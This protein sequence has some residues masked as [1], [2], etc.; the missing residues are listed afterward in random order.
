MVTSTIKFLVRECLLVLQWV[1]R[2]NLIDLTI[3]TTTI[4][5]ISVLT[6]VVDLIVMNLTNTDDIL[7]IMTIVMIHQEEDVMAGATILIMPIIIIHHQADIM[8]G[9]DMLIMN[10]VI[11][12]I[13]NPCLECKFKCNNSRLWLQ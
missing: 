3:I 13:M 5:I 10:M 7:L 6:N 4:V 11:C 12:T 9:E 1:A 2:T 8:A